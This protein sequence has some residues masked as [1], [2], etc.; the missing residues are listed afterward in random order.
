MGVNSNGKCGMKNPSRESCLATPSATVFATGTKRRGVAGL[1]TKGVAKGI[2]LL[3]PFI[4]LFWLSH[5][6]RPCH[7]CRSSEI[8][9]DDSDPPKKAGCP[10]DTDSGELG[11]R[12]YPAPM[13]VAIV[14]HLSL[15]E[16]SENIPQRGRLTEGR[17]TY[18]MASIHSSYP[19]VF[20]RA[21]VTPCG[22]LSGVPSPCLGRVRCST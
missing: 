6:N 16:G 8:G 4:I 1:W 17:Q 3:S 19:S 21:G 7:P 14:L 13:R 9:E 2:F 20:R 11:A 12:L 22:A 5:T 18:E 15:R 10:C